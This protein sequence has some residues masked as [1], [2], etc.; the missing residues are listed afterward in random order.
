MGSRA[1]VREDYEAD[2]DPGATQVLGSSSNTCEK[3]YLLVSSPKR[4]VG[5]EL[6]DFY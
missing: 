4:I 3:T 1:D 6:V 2:K 5:K